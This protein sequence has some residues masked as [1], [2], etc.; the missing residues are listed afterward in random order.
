MNIQAVSSLA[1][2]KSVLSACELLVAD[3]SDTGITEFFGL[4][5]AE[6]LVATIGLERHGDVGLLRSLAVL[7][8]WRRRGIGAALV[9]HVQGVAM[10]HGIS[11]L[12][13]L[14]TTAPAYFLALGFH[15]VPRDEA[16]ELIKASTQF[17]ALCPASAV[18]LARQLTV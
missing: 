16:P 4:S 14:T 13:L 9:Q 2:I 8:A 18:L 10:Q 5:A 17:S 15:P 6:Q 12:Y 11:S 1:S 3:I 7:P